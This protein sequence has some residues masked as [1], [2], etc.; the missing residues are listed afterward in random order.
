MKK[1]LF[2]K[3][4]L[5]LIPSVF[6]AFLGLANSVQASTEMHGSAL[7]SNIGYISFNCYDDV[8]SSCGASNYKVTTTADSTDPTN[9]NLSGYAWNDGIGWI[10]FG[11]ASTSGCP[12]TG[13]DPCHVYYTGAG[14]MHGFAKA[15]SAGDGWD[16]WINFSGVTVGATDVNGTQTLS[17][18]AWGSDVVGWTNMSGVSVGN[19]LPTVTL[20]AD[21][22]TFISSSSTTLHW[23]TTNA[24]VCGDPSPANWTTSTATSGNQTVSFSTPTTYYLT[25]TNGLNDVT[26]SISIQVGGVNPNKLTITQAS[27]SPVGEPNASGNAYQNANPSDVYSGTVSS[28]TS[29]CFTIGANYAPT[30]LTVSGKAIYVAVVPFDIPIS[31]R[32]ALQNGNTIPHFYLYDSAGNSISRASSTEDGANRFKIMSLG[33]YCAKMIIVAPIIKTSTTHCPVGGCKV[34]ISAVKGINYGGTNPNYYEAGPVS[35][36]FKVTPAPPPPITVSLT[37]NPTSL[38]SPGP[39]TLSWSSLNATS[40]TPDS[41]TG[42]GDWSPSKWPWL[43]N[44]TST[45]GSASGPPVSATTK[46]SITCTDGTNYKQAD[47]MVQMILPPV[48]VSLVASPAALLAPGYVNLSWTSTNAT[49]CTPGW[50]SGL[51]AITGSQ[52]VTVTNTKTF[53]ILCQNASSSAVA[54]MLVNVVPV[55]VSLT[56]DPVSL[57][58]GPGIATLTWTSNNATSCGSPSPAGWTSKTS[59]AGN[60]QVSLDVPGTYTYTITCSNSGKSATGQVTIVV[61]SGNLASDLWVTLSASQSFFIKSQLPSNTT[62]TWNSGNT[63]SCTDWGSNPLNKT[64]G[65]ATVSIKGIIMYTIVC[66]DAS[67]KTASDNVLVSVDGDLC[68]DPSCTAIPTGLT[69]NLTS[70]QSILSSPGSVKLSWVSQGATS[71]TPSW[72]DPP[73]DTS[74]VNG[75]DNVMVNNTEMFSILCQDSMGEAHSST[76]VVV[77]KNPSSYV[78]LNAVPRVVAVGGK[79]KLSWSSSPDFNSCTKDWMNSSNTST[80]GTSSSAPLSVKSMFSVTCTGAGGSMTTQIPVMVSNIINSSGILPVYKEQ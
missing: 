46:F 9:S 54:N 39:V 62:I 36:Y 72:Q 69:V 35:T 30:D 4:I 43:G 19:P 41:G 8:P 16:G 70:D 7:S 49:S 68:T 5:F 15:L 65:S 27:P 76:L 24:T 32:D 23:S 50:P 55:T 11:P 51:T 18:Y 3:T 34:S 26:G 59:T 45:N 75:G 1:H 14:N 58:N 33:T 12:S 57:P 21:N 17:G 48:T 52:M 77:N 10:Y 47:T 80:S 67:G 73:T 13:A 25:C 63:T 79:T 71:C 53:S 29:S 31:L 64:K 78:T 66:S 22:T 56:A 6:F 61:S 37:A 42:F 44:S 74:V 2:S 40:C 20:T 38:T 28:T 60:E